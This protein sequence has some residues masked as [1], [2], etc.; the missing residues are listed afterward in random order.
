MGK[1]TIH[2]LSN[3]LNNM[4]NEKQ[5]KNDNSLETTDK[6][7]VGAINEIYDSLVK[8]NADEL[9]STYGKKIIAEAIGEPLKETNSF[10]EMGNNINGLLSTFKTNMMNNGVVVESGDKFKTLIDKLATLA[11]NE[12]EGIQYASGSGSSFTG[13]NFAPTT[14]ALNIN[15]IPTIFIILTDSI[16]IEGVLGA[17]NTTINNIY[18][19]QNSSVIWSGSYNSITW[20]IFGY[21]QNLSNESVEICLDGG[22]ESYG[23][24][25]G[26]NVVINDFTWY[27]IGTGTDSTL[28]NSLLDLIVNG[29]DIID[30]T[31]GFV[32]SPVSTSNAV[33]P[34]YDSTNAW[35]NFSI[36]SSSIIVPRYLTCV[37][38]NPIDVS[39]YSKLMIDVLAND[40]GAMEA[41]SRIMIGLIR[42]KNDDPSTNILRG[43][44]RDPNI[45]PGN[46]NGCYKA[47]IKDIT[48]PCYVVIYIY[49]ADARIQLKLRDLYLR[50]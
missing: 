48:G 13:T 40:N 3:S 41:N 14:I 35:L 42:N 23:T 39:N 26:R 16:L 4:I 11:D 49:A 36:S 19:T 21:I 10:D 22:P 37:T 24:Y 28:G 34:F 15:F 12:G 43:F 47:N 7:I 50:S 8:N 2:E 38:E 17:V 6:T 31:G 33:Y 18:N 46:L 29:V 5:T 9:D 45:G 25:T 44:Y 27:A 30:N 20:K 32:M 1:I